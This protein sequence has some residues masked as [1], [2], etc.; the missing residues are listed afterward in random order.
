MTLGKPVSREINCAWLACTSG[1]F[2]SKIVVV[3]MPILTYFSGISFF[4][5]FLSKGVMLTVAQQMS[6]CFNTSDPLAQA[7][8]KQMP[9]C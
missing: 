7:C 9:T 3:Y 6:D 5:D 2:L 4:A 1:S 8:H